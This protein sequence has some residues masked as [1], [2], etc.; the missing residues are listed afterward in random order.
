VHLVSFQIIDGRGYSLTAKDAASATEALAAFIAERA[1]GT[2][3]ATATVDEDGVAS[4][5]YRG[6]TFYA[7][8][9]KA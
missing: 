4:V 3:L 9:P 2:V 1:K 6:M 7:V 8:P 5:K